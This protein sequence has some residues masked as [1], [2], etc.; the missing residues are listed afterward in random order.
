MRPTLALLLCCTLLPAQTPRPLSGFLPDSAQRELALEAKFDQAL[1]R[2]NFQQW[3]KRMS[4]K[5]HHVGSPG[6]KETAEFIAAQF[7]SWGYETTIETVYPLFPTPRT[8]LLEMVAP[9]RFTAKIEEPP[10]AG[11]ETSGIKDGN[12]P[13]YHAYSTDGDV[14]GDLVYVNYGLPDDYRKLKEMGIDVKGKIV[15]ARYGASWRGIKPKVAAENGAVG[16]LI[17]SDPRDDGY[18]MGDVYP[19]GAYRPAQGAQRGSVMDMP[20]YPGDPLTPFKAATDPNRA[21]DPKQAPTV[22]KIPVMPISY[23]DAEPLLR[24]LTGPVAPADWRGALPLTYHVGP[25]PAKVHLKLEFNWKLA[26]TYNVV[27]KMTG[28]EK[29]DQWVLRGNHHDGWNFGAA[30]PLSGMIA[31]MEEARVIA[32]L[33]KTGWRPGRTLVFLAWDGEEPALL[34]STEWAEHHASELQR[35]A[36]AYINSDGTSRGFVRVSGA[37]SLELFSTQAAR[38]VTDPQTRVP[39]LERSLA[40]RRVAGQESA[41]RLDP[42][43]SGSDYTVF[44]HHLGI[45]SLNIGFSGEGGGGVYHSNYDSYDHYVRFTDPD[46]QYVMA[47]AQLGG[48]MMLR[49][50]NADWLP[51]HADTT[52][53]AIR[54]WTNEVIKLADDLRAQTAKSNELI[55]RGDLKLVADPRKTYVVPA[56]EDDV[57]FLNFAPLQNAVGRLE[58][59]ATAI[60]KVDPAKLSPAKRQAFEDAL[61]VAEQ[62]FLQSEGLPRR[63][64]FR[65]VLHAPGFYTGYGVKTLPGIREAIEQRLWKEADTQIGL[66]S[67]ALTAYAT[68]LSSAA[69]KA[70][71]E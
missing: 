62:K 31:V 48:R 10:V 35:H 54:G 42:L 32:E 67:T 17:Y 18:F 56:P 59:A 24:A 46:F 11:D 29:P 37:S 20:V 65:H 53:R 28:A 13:T 30:D 22:T 44:Q 21:P 4:A 55:R 9:T 64:W 52:S 51:F 50:A 58:Q 43:G 69:T 40:A 3:M 41:F 15:L 2:Q 5:P 33:A 23:G 34:G 68:W 45:P 26:P 19:Q 36:V 63:P 66:T 60:G 70:T 12:L 57:P 25:G 39:V 38:D 27:A 16:C 49:M 8:R 6:S 1:N 47:T 7:K 71:A 14:T 61:R